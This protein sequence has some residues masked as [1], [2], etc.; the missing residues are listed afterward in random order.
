[1]ATTGNYSIF[2]FF[3][4]LGVPIYLRLEGE[5]FGPDFFNFLRS[6]HF[7]RLSPEEE[8]KFNKDQESGTF[9]KKISNEGTHFARILDVKMAG[10][11]VERK[12]N[13]G[14]ESDIFGQESL[15]DQ[16]TYKLYRY[17]GT[18]LIIYAFQNTNWELALVSNLDLARDQF[19]LRVVFH[20]FLTWVLA[21]MGMCGFWGHFTNGGIVIRRMKESFGEAVFVDVLSGRIFGPS[22]TQKITPQFQIYR[23]DQTVKNNHAMTREELAAFLFHSTSYM[24][25]TGPSVPLRQGIMWMA[26]V[27][28]GIIVNQISRQLSPQKEAPKNSP[29]PT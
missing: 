1:M 12:I 5:G 18:G 15:T 29:G 7:E 27:Y 24:D 4:E 10:P 9:N 16:G 11:L 6:L 21:P 13:L 23:L 28:R 19:A 2:Q 17:R 14:L 25:M 8:T 26:K 22:G 3:K 20:R